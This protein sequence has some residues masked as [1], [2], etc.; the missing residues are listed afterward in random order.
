MAKSKDRVLPESVRVVTEGLAGELAR[1]F[2][3]PVKLR[4]GNQ[5]TVSNNA[6]EGAAL[7]LQ[8]EA[9]RLARVRSETKLVQLFAGSVYQQAAH[10]L[11]P[12]TAQYAEAGEA[13]YVLHV[14]N[15]EHAL[16]NAIAAHPEWDAPMR[17][18]V[19]S[20]LFLKSKQKSTKIELP[21]L[22]GRS[23]EE[24]ARY[25]VPATAQYAERFNTW[26]YSFRRHVALP[27]TAEEAVLAA[28]ALVPE[29]LKDLSKDDVLKL[30]QE[31]HS[32]LAKDIEPEKEPAAVVEET[33]DSD[34]ELL[35]V[36]ERPSLR[37]FTADVV[38]PPKHEAE[39]ESAPVDPVLPADT[40]SHWWHDKRLVGV[41]LVSGAVFSGLFM[42]FGLTFWLVVAAFAS[43]AVGAIALGVIRYRHEI[44]AGAGNVR[45]AVAAVL[46][47]FFKAVERGW[48]GF[49]T[50]VC[51]GAEQVGAFFSHPFTKLVLKVVGSALGLLAL[52]AAFYWFPLG[53]FLLIAAV[54]GM[55]ASLAFV[56]SGGGGYF[57]T[58]RTTGDVDVAEVKARVWL[59][60]VLALFAGIFALGLY[61]TLAALGIGG[62]LMMIGSLLVFFV[63]LGVAAVYIVPSEAKSAYERNKPALQQ[64]SAAL[65]DMFK[66]FGTVV[67]MVL[68]FMWSIFA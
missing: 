18:Y 5:G 11:F 46:F 45:D 49:L 9:D 10:A 52:G 36:L 14:L 44:G 13:A 57:P 15:D 16:R 50:R 26:A 20:I 28:A 67:L 7:D 65:G 2:E 68:V 22:Y 24:P 63:V 3:R 27:E 34:E 19:D 33:P 35:Q 25:T 1:T 59:K 4:I 6:F 66:A 29:N 48:D 39:E 23:V 43:V 58:E 61:E 30:A 56:K 42:K 62:T 55:F 8:I 37:A 51:N 53:W 21:V 54:A 38:L 64:F 32:A 40:V 12:A 17:A 47:R 41:A 31:I 60:V